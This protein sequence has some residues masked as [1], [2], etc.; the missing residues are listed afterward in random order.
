MSIRANTPTY[1]GTGVSRLGSIIELRKNL[2]SLKA[3]MP[4]TPAKT[5]TPAAAPTAP[6]APQ[7]STST[8][9]AAQQNSAAANTYTVGKD[10]TLW[11]IAQSKLGDGNRWKEIYELNKDKIS[12]PNVIF[13]GLSLRLPGS[14]PAPT[15]TPPPA[16]QQ[17][18]S[19]TVGN[20]DTLWGIAQSQLGD[21][22]RWR[23]IYESNKD[24]ISNPNVISAGMVLRM[25]SGAKPQS[26]PAPAP[27]SSATYTVSGN[28]SL[29][30]IAQ[31]TLGDGNRWR[32]IYEL[33]R[34]KI[35]NPDVISA[36]MTLRLPSGASSPSSNPAPANSGINTNRGSFYIQQPNGWTCG[37]TSLTMALAAWGV[38]GANGNTINEMVRLTGTNSEDGVPGN[39][40]VLSNAA[41]QVG[42]QAQFVDDGSPAAVRA[43][44]NRGHGVVLN[45][46]LGSGGHFIYVAGIASDGRF[47]ICDPARSGIT[48]MNDSE[49]NHFAN[50]YSN[51][52][53]FAEIWK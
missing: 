46:S 14:A 36:G 23:E 33:N 37:P 50:G 15:P 26:N 17:Q 4:T 47:I 32:E 39:A 35:S 27:A 1:T 43:A 16:P 40:S 7:K 21:G 5:S 52:R 19:Y 53:G 10:D 28:D 6:A 31:S 42:M 30:S 51:P 29:W 2:Q 45:G 20:G 3:P 22:N 41:H 13:P 48:R 24:T 9:P 38:R 25:P 49:L 18:A 12:N 34:D 44:L 8:A 11:R